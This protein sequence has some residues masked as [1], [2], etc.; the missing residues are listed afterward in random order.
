[1]AITSSVV[2]FTWDNKFLMSKLMATEGIAIVG[3]CV[4]GELS[5]LWLKYEVP[6]IVA[7]HPEIINK[8]GT[9]MR[10]RLGYTRQTR[11]RP[12]VMGITNNILAIDVQD[13]DPEYQYRESEIG[14]LTPDEVVS[15]PRYDS[16]L[17]VI[18]HTVQFIPERISS[19]VEVSVNDSWKHIWK[20]IVHVVKEND[21][22]TGVAEYTQQ[23][24]KLMAPRMFYL[25]AIALINGNIY[26]PDCAMASIANRIVNATRLLNTL[27]RYTYDIF[28]ENNW[29]IEGDTPMP[30]VTIAKPDNIPPGFVS[31]QGN[32]ITM[33]INWAS[34]TNITT[35]TT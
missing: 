31:F 34:T 20:T 16:S 25:D 26:D 23:L 33:G 29:T 28:K 5:N 15:I 4:R 13:E 8:V 11:D 7:S 6:V 22:G 35:S 18:D 12:A 3:P 14:Y 24:L 1:M 21:S 10:S 2:D 32:S 9:I 19:L 17:V 30:K 27:P